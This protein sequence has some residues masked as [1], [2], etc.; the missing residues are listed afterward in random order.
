VNVQVHDLLACSIADLE[1]DVVPVGV[2]FLVEEHLHLVE[3]IK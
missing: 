2:A 1:T 3:E